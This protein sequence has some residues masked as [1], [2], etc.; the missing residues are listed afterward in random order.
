MKYHV[1]F[2][3]D[4]KRNPHKG[5]Y[6]AIEG[7]D[8]SGKDTQILQLK[9]YFSKQKRD[10]IVTSEPQSDLLVGKVIRKA[11]K[12]KIKLPPVALQY[13]YSAD[14]V[15]NHEQIVLPALNEGKIVLSHRV[16]W[17]AV[18]YGL[19]DKIMD[20][21][22]G[23]YDLSQRAHLMSA[24]GILSMYH[25]FVVPDKTFYLNISVDT[26]LDR[27]SRRKKTKEIY[28]KREALEKIKKGY[29]LL[30]HEFSKE[31]VVIDAEKPIDEVTQDIIKKIKL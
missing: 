3:I 18:P 14:R 31:F 7:I 26:A 29:D 4:L 2:D 30:L 17:S 28:E 9:E 21:M 22:D 27:L 5:L 12:E 11:L 10:V 13:L 23:K 25:Q 20:K 16:F 1:E 19:F 24:Q 6:I 8:G 15:L